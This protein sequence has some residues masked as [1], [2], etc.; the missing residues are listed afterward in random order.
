MDLPTS[1]SCSKTKVHKIT[2]VPVFYMS[3]VLNEFDGGKSVT[4][5]LEGVDPENQDFLR[6]K[7]Y[8]L[9]S[10]QFQSPKSLDFQA[11]PNQWPSKWIFLH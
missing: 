11:H 2:K 10:L 4:Q 3:I 5:A 8:L 6:P 9:C 7:W 1:H